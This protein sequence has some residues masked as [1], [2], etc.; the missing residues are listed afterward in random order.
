[1]MNEVK[2]NKDGKEET[3]YVK[4]AAGYTDGYYWDC[5]ATVIFNDV[6]YSIQDAGSYSGWIPHYRSV[7]IEGPKKLTGAQLIGIPTENEEY[8]RDEYYYIESVVKELMTTFFKEGCKACYEESE[9]SDFDYEIKID[10]I[11]KGER[12]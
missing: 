11:R 8:I 3:A 12:G 5:S 7:S 10:G 1:M 4:S 2:F 6:E 9:G